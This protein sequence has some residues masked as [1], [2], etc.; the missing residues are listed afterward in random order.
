MTPTVSSPLELAIAEL[1][2]EARSVPPGM[3]RNVIEG[4]IAKLEL[5]H[6][7]DEEYRFQ[8]YRHGFAEGMAVI[9]QNLA[10]GKATDRVESEPIH[11]QQGEIVPREERQISVSGVAYFA[12]GRPVRE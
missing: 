10:N 8:L 1:Q 11:D 6:R 7:A 2:K 3:R 4:V 9:K 5:L 12:N